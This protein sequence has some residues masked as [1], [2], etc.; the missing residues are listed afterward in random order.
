[1][2]DDLDSGP[3]EGA[4]SGSGFSW[5]LM[6]K[7]DS[8]DGEV[9]YGHTGPIFALAW[10]PED[11]NM[12]LSG[13]WDKSIQIWNVRL[14][15]AVGAMIGPY[16]C[17][18]GLGVSGSLVITGS[19]R[20]DSPLQ[21]WDL[22]TRSL[23]TNLPWV[24]PHY[25]ACFVYSAGIAYPSSIASISHHNNN[26]N[27][28]SNATA[29]SGGGAS[30]E[31]DGKGGGGN[32]NGSTKSK[33]IIVYGG[34]SGTLPVVRLYSVGGPGD[35]RPIGTMPSPSRRVIHAITPVPNGS[36]G[37][38]NHNKISNNTVNASGFNGTSNANISNSSSRSNANGNI[39]AISNDNSNGGENGVNNNGVSNNS[40][41]INNSG[42]KH[43][44]SQGVTL[45][46]LTNKS[47]HLLNV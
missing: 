45:A 47:L 23:S 15:R 28:N 36:S 21:L 9:T 31:R 29:T 18:E 2:S 32:A 43:A 42:N 39:A 44:L 12:L 6:R 37:M 35:V 3:A 30:S 27:S 5:R 33:R 20:D 38:T 40:T 11:P 17:G 8:G 13:G 24:Q 34:G 46:I 19:W 10:K 16:L 14:G 41:A 22:T 25:G 26:S 7:M 4:G 1:V